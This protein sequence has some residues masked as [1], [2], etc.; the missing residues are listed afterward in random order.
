MQLLW[1]ATTALWAERYSVANVDTSATE[2][3]ELA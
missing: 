2:A 1:L 3:W